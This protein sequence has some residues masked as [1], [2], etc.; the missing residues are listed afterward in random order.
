MHRLRTERGHFGTEVMCEMQEGERGKGRVPVR[1]F[2]F[3]QDVAGSVRNLGS[4][5]GRE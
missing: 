4:T 2:R 5:K 3:S 1:R